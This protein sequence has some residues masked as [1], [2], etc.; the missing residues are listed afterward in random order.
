M[1]EPKKSLDWCE[2]T[3]RESL[4][5]D[6]E[7]Y[8]EVKRF[9]SKERR[10]R[11]A[12]AMKGVT[13]D[14]EAD[15]TSLDVAYDEI[16]E[17]EYDHAIVD[18]RLVSRRDGKQSVLTFNRDNPRK[19]REVYDHFSEELEDFVDKLIARVNKEDEKG[20]PTEEVTEIEGNSNGSS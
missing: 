3:L 6:S 20:E 15:S 4:P 11:K 8:I 9:D 18:F 12:L 7:Q 10:K 16:K 14:N 2:D 5:W 19:N 17:Y 13:I 1:E